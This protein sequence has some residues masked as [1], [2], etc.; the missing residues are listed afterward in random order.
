VGC[1]RTAQRVGQPM[2]AGGPHLPLGAPATWYQLQLEATSAEINVLASAFL[3]YRMS[4]RQNMSEL[5]GEIASVER[6]LPSK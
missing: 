6:I 2:L 3:A 5:A 4:L 1:V